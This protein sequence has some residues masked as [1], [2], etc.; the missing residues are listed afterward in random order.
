MGLNDPCK[1]I[2]SAFRAGRTNPFGQGIEANTPT[3]VSFDQEIFDVNDEYDPTTSTFTAKEEGVY[4]FSF[5]LFFST[6]SAANHIFD[7]FIVVNNDLSNPQT[8]FLHEL[9]TASF[10]SYH[11]ATTVSL[12]PSDTVNVQVRSAQS[13]VLIGDSTERHFEG[14]RFPSRVD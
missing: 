1:S 14:A 11:L 10:Q 5:T 8:S 2:C 9:N 3:V 4:S 6:N 12:Q 13:G 7:V